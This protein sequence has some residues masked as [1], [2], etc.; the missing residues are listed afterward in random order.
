VAAD[1]R[2]WKYSTN[3]SFLSARRSAASIF[4]CVSTRSFIS[5]AKNA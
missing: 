1:T 5:R 4:I 2:G 3:S